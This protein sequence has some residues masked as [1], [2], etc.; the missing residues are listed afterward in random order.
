MLLKFDEVQI[1]IEP[2]NQICIHKE[3]K[4]RLNSGNAC[5]HSLHNVYSSF[6]LLKNINIKICNIILPASL[7]ECEIWFLTLREGYRLRVSRNRML[8]ITFGPICEKVIDN[9]EKG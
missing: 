3:I 4:S 8:R 2:A 6:M 1:G 7:Y 9:W 5:Y